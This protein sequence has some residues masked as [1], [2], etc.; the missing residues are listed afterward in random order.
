[1]T[2]KANTFLGGTSGATVTTANSGGVSGTAFDSVTLTGAGA[3]TFDATPAATNGLA[4][5]IDRGGYGA[6]NEAAL[7]WTMPAATRSGGRLELFLPSYP[8]GAVP[9][10]DNQYYLPLVTI[11]VEYTE[12][13]LFIDNSGRLLATSGRGLAVA[14]G[15][16]AIPLNQWMRI[17]WDF[18]TTGTRTYSVKLFPDRTTTTPSTVL[19][20][21]DPVDLDMVC[22]DVRFGSTDADFAPAYL[23]YWLDGLNV[24]DTGLPGPLSALDV[25]SPAS[26][27]GVLAEAPV[28]SGVAIIVAAPAAT[29]GVLTPAPGFALAMSSPAAVAGVYTPA[30]ML[31][32][33][34]IRLDSP[35]PDV[36]VPSLRP[37]FRITAATTEFDAVVEVQYDTDP[38]FSDPATV[39]IPMVANPG[40][41]AYLSGRA[42]E[43]LIDDTTYYWRARPLNGYE[44]GAWV[45]PVEFAISVLDGEALAGGTWV[46]DP[47][48]VPYPHLWWVLP[49]R[50]RPGDD[51]VAVG[52]GF[53]P[54]TVSVVLSGNTSPATL[55][56]VAA[57]ADAYTDDRVLDRDNDRISPAHQRVVFAVPAAPPPGG[58]LFVDGS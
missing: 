15:F 37:V 31:V 9:G 53:G 28:V 24:N 21:A 2:T 58:A 51:A 52:T 38:M 36:P 44:T 11:T 54:T 30:P 42:G 8:P 13:Q 29:A 20:G 39:S 3:I 19:S 23:S 41:V 32:D 55:Y 49:D 26:V 27:A 57:D 48:H 4:V 35:N 10:E 34:V 33:A 16:A 5:K 50:G 25:T 1:M 56:S 46:V 18:V 43:D 17:E 40:G 22:S 12:I 47:I 45:G 7:T 6:G 14:T